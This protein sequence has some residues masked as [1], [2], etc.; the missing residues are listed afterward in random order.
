MQYKNKGRVRWNVQ[1]QNTDLSGMRRQKASLF[2]FARLTKAL[3]VD[4]IK[5]NPLH[6]IKPISFCNTEDVA[7]TAHIHPFRHS[8]VR[9]VP[10]TTKQLVVAAG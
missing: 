4:W 8:D 9:F 6:N 2:E 5:V 10:P 7:G 1:S 3:L